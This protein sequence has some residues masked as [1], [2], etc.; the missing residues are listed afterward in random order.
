TKRRRLRACRGKAIF[1]LKFFGQNKKSDHRR[2]AKLANDALTGLP[3]LTLGYVL[4]VGSIRVALGLHVLVVVPLFWC[5]TCRT[6]GN[7]FSACTMLEHRLSRV[8]GI[9]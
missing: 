2:L 9:G 3:R 4:P 6:A 1:V 5:V 7:V 8:G